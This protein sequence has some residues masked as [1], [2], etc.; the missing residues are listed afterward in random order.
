M[1]EFKVYR[2]TSTVKAKLFE[3][4]DEDGFVHKNGWHGA[5]EDAKYELQPELVPYVS[6]LENQFHHG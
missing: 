6:T 1:T 5:M 4:G 3:N 2:K